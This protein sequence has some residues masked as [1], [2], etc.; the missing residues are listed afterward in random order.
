MAKYLKSSNISHSHRLSVSAY[1]IVKSKNQSNS[2]KIS[3]NSTVTTIYSSP[4]S[5]FKDNPINYSFE[6]LPKTLTSSDATP[7]SPSW[8]IISEMI[9]SHIGI[10]PFSQEIRTLI[11]WR[12]GKLENKSWIELENM[13]KLVT[14]ILGF[15]SGVADKLDKDRDKEFSIILNIKKEVSLTECDFQEFHKA[16]RENEYL[17]KERVLIDI[18]KQQEELLQRPVPRITKEAMLEKLMREIMGLNNYKELGKRE[19]VVKELEFEDVQGVVFEDHDCS[20]SCPVCME[21]FVVGT[22]IPRLP[23]SHMFHRN[24]IGMWLKKVPTCP[25]CRF[26]LPITNYSL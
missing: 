16:R 6:L 1:E 22:L 13:N 11:Q 3:I 20:K 8:S 23:C 10:P 24:C 26:K 9:L 7:S 15:A 18:M 12:C 2:G 17:I 5:N 4:S 21:K 25:L 19:A 14:C